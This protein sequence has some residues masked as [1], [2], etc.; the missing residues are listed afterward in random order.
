MANLNSPERS[1]A[2]QKDISKAC[3]ILKLDEEVYGDVF[4]KIMQA[5]GEKVTP[6]Y[7]EQCV[8]PSILK[9]CKTPDDFMQAATILLEAVSA[10]WQEGSYD[11]IKVVMQE[12]KAERVTSM[13]DLKTLCDQLVAAN[14]AFKATPEGSDKYALNGTQFHRFIEKIHQDAVNITGA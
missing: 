14:N 9:I 5:W 3:S 2:Q 6:A 12:I 7:L 10:V 13:T 4:Y 11:L 1:D 8:D